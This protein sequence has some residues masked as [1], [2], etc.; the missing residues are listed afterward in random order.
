MVVGIES[1]VKPRRCSIKVLTH[2]HA[3][4]CD[5]LGLWLAKIFALSIS[6]NFCPLSIKVPW[7]KTGALVY[8]LMYQHTQLIL[9][10]SI[11]STKLKHWL[12]LKNARKQS[13]PKESRTT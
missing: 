8:T 3:R 4:R 7:L 9:F 11:N 12:Q 13:R 6:L 10:P 5:T 1:L 2:Q